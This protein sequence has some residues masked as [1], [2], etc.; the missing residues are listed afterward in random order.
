MKWEDFYKK[1]GHCPIITPPMLYASEENK[2]ILQV[3]LSRW[4]KDKKLIKLSREKYVFREP[5]QKKTSPYPILQTN[6]F[7][8]PMSV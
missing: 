1:F 7:T 2:A 4:V 3:Q 6:S 5:Y 8:P